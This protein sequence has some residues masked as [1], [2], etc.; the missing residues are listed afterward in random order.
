MRSFLFALIPGLFLAD[1]SRADDPPGPPPLKIAGTQIQTL[2]GKAVRLRG[3]NLPG[4]MWGERAHLGS[5]IRVA[6]E[7]W[8]ANIIRVC[9]SPDLW[10]GK[11]KGD[12]DGGAG[13]RKTV[14]A[15]VDQ[16]AARHCYVILVLTWY[17]DARWGENHVS[18][19]KMPD[20]DSV[21]FW[22]DLATAFAHQP[23][24]LFGLYNEPWGVPWQVWRNGGTVT[25]G[26]DKVPGDR[27]EYHTPGL[28]KLVDV[29]RS[30]GA[31]NLIVAGGL[32][33]AY[34][35]T[36]IAE[37]FALKDPKGHGVVY[38][39]HMYSGKK[40]HMR[41]GKKDWEWDR[42][43]LSGGGK[44]PVI[45][46]EFG[47]DAAEFNAKVLEFAAEHDLPWIAWSFHPSA[48][49]CL[50]KDWNYVPTNIGRQVKDALKKAPGTR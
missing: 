16:V 17:G 26:N 38:D 12:K 45:I 1:S 33:W 35:L 32:D 2:D 48:K 11:A 46:G 47:D 50:I 44:Y 5:S 20:D 49:P 24:V 8:G 18:H 9:L 43:V 21:A 7:E 13:Y 40:W 6:T 34:D 19:H 10:Y 37:G 41:N 39:T 15:V 42:V 31:R 36:G 14:H 23:A 4:L 22:A 30:K 3:V 28:Q 29:C 25:E 27:R